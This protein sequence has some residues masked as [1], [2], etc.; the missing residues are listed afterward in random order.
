MNT[1]ILSILDTSRTVSKKVKYVIL[2]KIIKEFVTKLFPLISFIE[3][4]KIIFDLTSVYENEII[5]K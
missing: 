5:S 4:I 2:K 1:I 3:N